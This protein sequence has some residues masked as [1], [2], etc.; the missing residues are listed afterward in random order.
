M[1]QVEIIM[2]VA[3]GFGTAALIALLLGR[4]LWTLAVGVGRRRVQRTA[5]PPT[6]AGLQA[7]RN[8]LRAEYAMLA[9]RVEVRLD[10]LKLQVAEQ[11]AEVSRSRNR[12]ERLSA[13]IG[14]REAALSE[15]EGEIARLKE[16]IQTLEA[17]LTARTG[18]LHELQD[19]HSKGG[20][21]S[22]SLNRQLAERDQYIERLRAEIERLGLARSEA[23]SRERTVQERLKGR[24]EDLSAL[25]RQIEAQRRDLL[26]QQSQSLVLRETMAGQRQSEPAEGRDEA[27]PPEQAPTTAPLERRIE[28]AERQANEVQSELDRLGEMWAAKLADVARAVASEPVAPEAADGSEPVVADG[29]AGKPAADP[30]SAGLVGRPEP[31]VEPHLDEMAP[32]EGDKKTPSGLANVI[33]LAQRIR[34]LQ[35]SG[36]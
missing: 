23:M 11:M 30:V 28:D 35:R 32:A 19:E 31:P 26:V 3:L 16:Q 33:S 34:A 12:I 24:I 22:A 17:E 25:S 20:E 9:R 10:D 21:T 8:Q 18:S 27:P 4:L 13:E 1:G 14:K 5:P 7:E 15:R 29:S 2:Y 36:S 6:V